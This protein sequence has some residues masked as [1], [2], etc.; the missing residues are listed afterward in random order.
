MLFTV[1]GHLLLLVYYV[2]I[3][4]LNANSEGGF[5]NPSRSWGATRPV[6]RGVAFDCLAGSCCGGGGAHAG[7]L[8]LALGWPDAV[9]CAHAGGLP[10]AAP[11]SRLPGPRPALPNI[12][13]CGTDLPYVCGCVVQVKSIK[14]HACL[15]SSTQLA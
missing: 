15:P 7:G 12:C 4:C 5:V 3:A 2:R 1:S 8:P 11:S 10:R 9:A 6:H 14:I 13:V